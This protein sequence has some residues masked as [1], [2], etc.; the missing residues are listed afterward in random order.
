M[1][2]A[3]FVSLEYRFV[4]DTAFEMY[5]GEFK[6]TRDE[7]AGIDLRSSI[8]AVIHP[9]EQLLIGVG[10]AINIQTMGAAAIVL[11]RSGLGVKGLVLGNLVGLIDCGYQDEMKVCV[12]NRHDAESG[13][14]GIEIKCGDRIAQLVLIPVLHPRLIRVNQ[15]EPSKRGLAGMGS[16]GVK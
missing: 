8:D 15:F 3:P 13:L 4:S 1:N 2:E 12:W 7:D 10:V 16:S 11:P 6:R 14:D 5:G 9:G